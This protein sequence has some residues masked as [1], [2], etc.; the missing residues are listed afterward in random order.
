MIEELKDTVVRDTTVTIVDSVHTIVNI[1]ETRI[2][3]LQDT[4]S[5]AQPD[6]ITVYERLITA[7]DDKFEFTL[8][9]I[10]IIVT[11]LIVAV[12]AFNFFGAKELFKIEFKKMLDGERDNIK[13]A[14]LEDVEKELHLIKGESARLFANSNSTDPKDIANCINWW[15]SYIKEYTLADREVGVSISYNKLKIALENAV[16]SKDVFVESFKD[17]RTTFEDVRE[18]VAFLP[19]IV[20][21]KKEILEMLDELEEYYNNPEEVIEEAEVIV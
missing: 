11:V 20:S 1:T 17:A 6:L 9:L 21:E 18:R 13:K 16:K 10:A 3:H 2:I 8:Y 15:A 7:Q 12:T 19:D 5:A 14:A 4:I